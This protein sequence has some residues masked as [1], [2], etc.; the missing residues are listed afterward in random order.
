[1]NFI[2]LYQILNTG[3][4]EQLNLFLEQNNCFIKDNKIFSNEPN[5]IKN[6][7]DYFSRRQLNIKIL[8]NSTYG[9]LTNIG[10]RFYDWRIGQSTTLSGRQIAK[11][12]AAKINEIICE[13]YDHV[14]K[15]IIF[16]DTDSA[17]FSAYPIFK[18]DIENGLITWNKDTV[19]QLYDH[20]AEE[21][22]TSFP[23]FIFKTFHA[24]LEKGQIVKAGREI[25]GRRG[26]FVKKK[27]Y[28]ILYFDKEGTRKDINGTEGELK[29]MG[30]EIKRTDTPRVIQDFLQTVL[31][32]VLLGKSED[33][34][35]DTITNFKEQFKSR[36]G[37]EKGSP[38]AVNNLTKYRERI[39][40]GKV[41]VPGH[42]RAALNW[43]LLKEFYDDKCSLSILDGSKIVVCKL[44]SNPMGFTSVAYPVDELRLPTWFKELPFDHEAMQDTLIDDKIDNLIGILKFNLNKTRE[45]SLFSSFFE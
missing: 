24:P 7:M 40:K 27:K 17:G 1:M 33:I 6:L 29:T 13:D 22:N 10:S 26:L 14:G 3:T 2:E 18:D 4:K 8:L 12:M 41:S 11:H 37:W 20:I 9:G 16:G 25:V 5:K 32:E 36:P 35:L 19:I 28:S 44:K 21:V 38:K 39:L 23:E 31:E 15:S 30:L 43:N 34:I 42:V 45:T